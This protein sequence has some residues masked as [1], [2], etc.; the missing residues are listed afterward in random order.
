MLCALV[1][2]VQHITQGDSVI[3]PAAELSGRKTCTEDDVSLSDFAS[4]IG[5]VRPAPHPSRESD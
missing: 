3:Y 1:I 2:A 5:K 4:F